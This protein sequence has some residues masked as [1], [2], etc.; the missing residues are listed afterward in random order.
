MEEAVLSGATP[1][2]TELVQVSG[3]SKAPGHNVKE[4]SS[5]GHSRFAQPGHGAVQAD[6]AS[7][8]HGAA[9]VLLLRRSAPH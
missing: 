5:L 3:V 9:S 4:D 8:A 2:R 6:I 1:L 7:D